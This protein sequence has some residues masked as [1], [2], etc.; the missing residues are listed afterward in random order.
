LYR[1]PA[2]RSRDLTLDVLRG[3]IAIE[4][5]LVIAHVVSDYAV[6]GRIFLVTSESNVPTWFSST[7][8]ILVAVACMWLWRSSL[9]PDRYWLLLGFVFLLFSLDEIAM[10]H[11][12][13]EAHGSADLFQFVVEPLIGLAVIVIFY[14]AMQNAGERTRRFL[15]IAIVALIASQA[16]S[17]AASK[18]YG[19]DGTGA[20]FDTLAILEEVFKF[21][22]GSFALAAALDAGAVELL[23]A[24]AQ[25]SKNA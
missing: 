4:V 24:P 8:F 10:F 12:R 17:A 5:L 7:Q 21:L 6:G 22:T 11:E 13:I 15:L 3:L 25:S 23:R 20:G 1:Y 18:I 9:R 16:C 19:E 14:R 2:M